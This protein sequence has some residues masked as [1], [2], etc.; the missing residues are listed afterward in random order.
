MQLTSGCLVAPAIYVIT[1]LGIP[2]I[3][4]DGA[5]SSQELAQAT[6]MNADALYRVLRATA[7]VGVL[8]EGSGQVFSNS[9]LSDTLRADWPRST[10]A[11]TLW[12]LDPAHWNVYGELMY[13]VQTGKTAWNKV[14][15]E[16]CF[17][18]RFGSM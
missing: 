8:E 6:G 7:S 12:M 16:P 3:L 1:K 11:M 5:R 4:K 15:G 13:S 9:P 18:S 14:Y 17:E 10:R 2:D